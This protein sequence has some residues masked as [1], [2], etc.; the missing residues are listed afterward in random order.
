MEESQI[1]DVA[2]VKAETEEK[3]EEKVDEGA[4]KEGNAT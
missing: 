3:K 4:A 1:G 2:A